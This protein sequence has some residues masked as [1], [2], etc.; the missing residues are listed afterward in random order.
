MVKWSG[1]EETRLGYFTP[2]IRI[3]Q[4]VLLT[5]IRWT[6]KP[7]STKKADSLKPILRLLGGDGLASENKSSR[8][9][10]NRAPR[11]RV[12][13]KSSRRGKQTTILII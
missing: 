4:G 5:G 6:P 2:N 8:Q 11:G 10:R 13:P 12:T 9:G 7:A 3:F 1:G